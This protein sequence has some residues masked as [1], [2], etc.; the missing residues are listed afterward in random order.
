VIGAKRV[1]APDGTTWRVGRRWLPHTPTEWR[2]SRLR[3]NRDGSWLSDLGFGDLGDAIALAVAIL[4]ATAILLFLTTVVF[5]LIVLTVELVI[6]LALL[7]GGLAGRLVFRKPWTIRAR[8][9]DGRDLTWQARGWRRSG[10]VRDEVA[11]ALAL[12]Q[13]DLRPAEALDPA[14][15]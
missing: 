14:R 15:P 10:R 6:V 1:T 5:P 4:V 9:E 13:T 3:L 2:R 8:A 11:Q 7:M 12:G